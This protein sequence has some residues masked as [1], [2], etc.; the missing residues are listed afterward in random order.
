MSPAPHLSLP[1]A[2]DPSPAVAV[3]ETV[4]CV[5]DQVLTQDTKK[6]VVLSRQNSLSSLHS[7]GQQQQQQQMEEDQQQQ[8]SSSTVAMKR[9]S[10][11]ASLNSLGNSGGQDVAVATNVAVSSNH[12]LPPR[13]SSSLSQPST[14][15]QQQQQ[16]QRTKQQQHQQHLEPFENVDPFQVQPPLLQRR[17]SWS[18]IDGQA[19]PNNNSSNN[20]NIANVTDNDGPLMYEPPSPL[21]PQVSE[22]TLSLGSLSSDEE[23]DSMAA[24]SNCTEDDI[25]MKRSFGNV[26]VHLS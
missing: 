20:T 6:M 1:L 21:V 26:D 3:K 18:S 9:D 13:S 15:Q 22:S 16:Q 8:A 25:Q 10:S 7:H 23:D 17:P 2:M 11:Y 24:S 14:P 12:K 4:P 19:P 5:M